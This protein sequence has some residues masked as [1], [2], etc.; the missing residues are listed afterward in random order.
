M[1]VQTYK[2]AAKKMKE[3]FIDNLI[4]E[5]V[6]RGWLQQD[7]CRAIGLGLKLKT[8]QSWEEK[9]GFPPPYYQ[10]RI[11]TLLGFTLETLFTENL[12]R[13]CPSPGKT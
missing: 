6:E 3:T 1:S 9:R 8:Y 13:A 7:M 2:R 10:L 12:K 5:R 4:Y 11:A